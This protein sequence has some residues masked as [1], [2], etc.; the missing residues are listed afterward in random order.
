MSVGVVPLV[1]A[2]SIASGIT[3]LVGGLFKGQSVAFQNRDAMRA[4]YWYTWRRIEATKPYVTPAVA[5]AIDAGTA[6]KSKR[7]GDKQ[8]DID[9][10]VDSLNK[11]TEMTGKDYSICVTNSPAAWTPPQSWI[12]SAGTPAVSEAGL[13]GSWLFIL[14]G[15]G[16][17]LPMLFSKKG[18]KR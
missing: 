18:R 3:K 15:A 12:G 16:L 7:T 5:A 13:G 2:S 8:A 1:A 17:L 10:T 11:F 6:E 9:W 4:Y 14:V